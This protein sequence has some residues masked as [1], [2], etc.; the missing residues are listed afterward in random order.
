MVSFNYKVLDFIYKSDN[1]IIQSSK[2][3][4]SKFIIKYFKMSMN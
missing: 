1:E 3:Y 2:T 4:N